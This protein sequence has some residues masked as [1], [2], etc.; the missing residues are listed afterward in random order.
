[1][2]LRILATG[3]TFDKHYNELNGTLGFSDSHLPAAIARARMTAPVALEQLPLL[4][5]LDMQDADRQRVL[6]SCRAA[7]EKAIVIIHGTDTMR[8][9]AQVLGAA[10]LKQTVILTGAM[11]PYEIDNSD[12]LF[13]LGFACGVAQTLPAGVYVAMNGQIFAWDNVQKNRAA[14]VFQPL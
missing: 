11:I 13:N 1:M 7:Q 6:A 4:D 10:N 3:G 9:T 12:A 2:T 8:E 14:G 5:S